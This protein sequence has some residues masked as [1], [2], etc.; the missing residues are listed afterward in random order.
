MLFDVHRGTTHDG[1]GMRTTLFLKGCPL[2]CAWCHNPE[3]LHYAPD[4]S[5]QQSKC[6]GCRLC[7]KNAKDNAI[8]DTPAGIKIMDRE[9]CKK[10][11]GC[12]NVCPSKAFT[13]VG[14]E[15]TIE[16][17]KKIALKDQLYFETFSGGVT[18]SG[19][20]PL[21]QIDAVEELLKQLH[22]EKINTAIDTCGHVPYSSFERVLP[23][24]N[25]ILFDVKIM[26]NAMHKKWTGVSNTLI[27]ENLAKLANQMN[28]NQQ[29]WIRTPLIPS[30]TA[31]KENI[32]EIC[33][34][35][36]DFKV[37][38]R[39]ELCAFNNIC[40]EKYKKLGMT[41]Y[42]ENTPLMMQEEAESYFEIVKR[43]VGDRA[44]LSGLTAKKE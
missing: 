30:A 31:S 40:K 43:Y 15:K 25:N 42:F 24:V 38:K 3:S 36:K 23:Y 10:D 5:W 16:E 4:L 17:L 41:W 19:G 35:I 11:F 27:L 20:E 44:V 1:P 34:F 33:K 29:L 18:I 21:F 32:E 14:E 39:Y 2:R 9:K 22:A 7:V 8:I 6:I 37:L 26:D 12:V 13:K 28:E